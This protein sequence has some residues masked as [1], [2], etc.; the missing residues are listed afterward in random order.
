M[1]ARGKYDFAICTHTIED[2]AYPQVRWSVGVDPI[3]HPA[4][5]FEGLLL[6]ITGMWDLS[7]PPPRAPH[8]SLF[9]SLSLLP[10]RHERTPLAKVALDMLGAIAKEGFL[11]VPSKFRELALPEVHVPT[12]RCHHGVVVVGGVLVCA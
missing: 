2:L 1:A 9:L 8:I 10:A 11:A 5:L 3:I 7:A 6:L 4:F 12:A